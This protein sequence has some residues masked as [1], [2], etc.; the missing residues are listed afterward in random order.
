MI[1]PIIS[2]VITAYNEELNIRQ[3]VES[4]LSQESESPIEVIVVDDGSRDN[5]GH[6]C[7]NLLD[8]DDRLNLIQLHR[9]RG[10]VVAGN[11]GFG[12]ARG[13]YVI[14]LDGDDI[15]Y[16]SLAESLL[17]CARRERAE[18]VIGG[19]VRNYV[20][21]SRK[22]AVR[23]PATIR[24]F[25][26]CGNLI[27]KAAFQQ[28]GGLRDLRFEEYDLF[29]RLQANSRFTWNDD[30]LY[31]YRIHDTSLCHKQ[32]YWQ[33]GIRELLTIWPQETL[34]GNG[35]SDLLKQYA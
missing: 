12:A 25:I 16:P 35:F 8:S 23:H 24:D 19:Y 3:A 7:S 32:D 4:A 9:N 13:K 31:E 2:I 1:S 20:K 33:A 28:V 22:E 30:A 17:V 5:T 29:L 34:R 10:H 6:I 26:M 27:S 18:I 14:R 21:E 15:I 11:A